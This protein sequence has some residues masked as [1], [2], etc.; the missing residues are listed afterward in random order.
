MR[1]TGTAIASSSGPGTG[2][3]RRGAA[4]TSPADGTRAT[5]QQLWVLALASIGSFI[6]VLDM[7]I[8]AT[9]LTTIQRSLHASGTDLE[10]TVNAYTLSS[11]VFLMTAAALGD[12]FGRRRIF[13]VGLGL[14]AVASAGCALAPNVGTLIVARTVQG[15]GAAAVLPL[16]LALLNAAIPPARRG[17]AMGVYGGVTGLSAVVGPILGGAI[18]QSIGWEWIF[19]LNVPIAI[20]AIVLLFARVPESFGAKAAID[21]P[22]LALITV[23][24]FG[25]VWGLVRANTAGW[26]SAEIVG[27]LAGGAAAVLLFVA[28]E[29]RA[30]VPMLP[31]RLFASRAFS[32]SNLAMF[33]LS[34][35]LTGAVFFTAQYFQVA[36]GEGALGAGLRLLPWGIAPLLVA[37][38]AG[39]LSDRVGARPLMLT[40]LVVHA[41]GLAWL[42]AVVSPDAAYGVLIG[43]MTVAGVGFSLAVPAIIRSVMSSVPVADVGKASG[44]YATMRQ[45]GSAFGLAVL[46]AVFART[47]GYESANA[48]SDGVAT[49]MAIGSVLAII[50]AATCLL[51][52]RLQ[53]PAAAPA[54][55]RPTTDTMS[56]DG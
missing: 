44:T 29:R 20:A 53:A 50:G 4:D 6:V 16:A 51:V 5:R 46:A 2:D 42:A 11:A 28:W 54:P 17:W 39:A 14:F 55:A 47:G 36:G 43:P 41:I 45:L 9:A 12:R 49:A 27:S 48:F 40:G 10:W 38:R 56:I 21:V 24:A 37:P 8:V 30:T 35:S 22:G 25:I 3:Q 23:A 1:E 26:G 18:T 33:C 31:P 52:P 7:L 15:I 13:A 32:A 34:G 19:W